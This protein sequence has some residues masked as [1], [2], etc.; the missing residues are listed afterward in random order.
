MGFSEMLERW[1]LGG[2]A[3]RDV[4][5]LPL[6]QHGGTLRLRVQV[7]ERREGERSS[8]LRLEYFGRKGMRWQRIAY[9][10]T[11]EEAAALRGFLDKAIEQSG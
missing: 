8:R 10:L 5:S 6:S 11:R 4:G 1:F 3:L 2:K 9:L 7:L